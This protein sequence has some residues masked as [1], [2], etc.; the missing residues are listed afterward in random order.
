MGVS[1][2]HPCRLRRRQRRATD[3]RTRRNARAHRHGVAPGLPWVA[4]DVTY[5]YVAGRAQTLPQSLFRQIGVTEGTIED[6]QSS[7]SRRTR[8]R[9]L[10]TGCSSR[11]EKDRHL[12][13]LRQSFLKRFIRYPLSRPGHRSAVFRPVFGRGAVV[14]EQVRRVVGVEVIP[15]LHSVPV[16]EPTRV[17]LQPLDRSLL[18]ATLSSERLPVSLTVETRSPEPA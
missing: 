7:L 1:R 11:G 10:A 17:C 16:Y 12:V 2:P 8:D 3:Q 14:G 4:V 5:L 9:T 6:D 18:T 13:R 15:E